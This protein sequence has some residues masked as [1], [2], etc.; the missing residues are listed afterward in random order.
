MIIGGFVTGEEVRR[1]MAGEERH[2]LAATRRVALSE[3]EPVL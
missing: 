1:T 2:S 3:L